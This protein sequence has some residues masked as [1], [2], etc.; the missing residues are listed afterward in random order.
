MR[1]G[2]WLPGIINFDCEH[3][4]TRMYYALSGCAQLA[5]ELAKLSFVGAAVRRMSSPNQDGLG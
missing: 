3:T 4:I 5:P 2:A 1:D